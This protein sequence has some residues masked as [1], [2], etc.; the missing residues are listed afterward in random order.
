MPHPGQPRVW[1]APG[2]VYP[3]S[4]AAVDRPSPRLEASARLGPATAAAPPLPGARARVERK[5]GGGPGGQ[6]GAGIDANPT[7]GR[8]K[9]PL[10]SAAGAGPVQV[11]GSVELT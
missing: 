9:A 5:S 1:I 7:V 10:E 8:G 11:I 2:R 6:V 3:Q 4:D